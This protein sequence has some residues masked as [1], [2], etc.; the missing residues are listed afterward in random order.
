MRSLPMTFRRPSALLVL[1]PLLAVIA[2][3][4]A[5]P[6][7]A[8][9]AALPSAPIQAAL[10]KGDP[11]AATLAAEA[12]LKTSPKDAD[13]LL[14]AGRA[15]GQRALSASIF[16]KMSWAKKCRQAWERAIEIAPANAEARFELFR[17]YLMAPGIAGGGV[18]KARAQA[19][20]LTELDPMRGYIAR[21]MI[22][23]HEKKPKEAEAAYRKA[24]EADQ[25]G[26]QGPIALASFY[27]RQK[28][29]P[30][31]RAIFERRVAADPSDALALYQLGRLSLL[32]GEEMEKGLTLFDRFLSLDAPKD[33]PTH[34]DARWR[35]GL[36]LEK[37]GRTPSAIAEYREAL[38]AQPGHAGAKRELE[39]LKA[40]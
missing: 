29:W 23:D 11:E 21:G 27:A 12:A 25:F 36:L 24:M 13:I 26:V 1:A 19:V 37:L 35:K 15:Y 32:S 38:K 30:E 3:V 40:A 5:G 18:D 33:G 39:R 8:A 34:G 2:V 31:A 16:T 17:Y 10:E 7:P 4:A 6:A 22:A 9:I 20:K 14:W 28:R